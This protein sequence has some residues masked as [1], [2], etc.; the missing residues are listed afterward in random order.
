MKATL[1]CLHGFLGRAADWDSVFPSSLNFRRIN[2]DLFS[3]STAPNET[4]TLNDLGGWVN[5]HSQSQASPRILLGYSLGG[6]IALHSLIQSPE[7]WSA[8]VIVSAHLGLRRD[9]EDER[10]SR[11]MGDQYWAQRFET[12][13]WSEVVEEWDAQ[14][15]FQGGLRSCQR[16]RSRL[17]KDFLRSKLA[18]SFKY[19]SLGNQIDLRPAL[20]KIQVPILWIS[21]E[22]DVK[23][24]SIVQEA[25]E[26]NPRFRSVVI[27]G[28]GHRI[29][30]EMPG[31]FVQLIVNYLKEA[32]L[33]G[34][35]T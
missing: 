14:G 34:R 12:G 21:G 33:H 1:Y 25:A 3:P 13:P 10:G 5:T 27:P 11:L 28:G 17:E 7:H 24:R 6:R 15:V 22:Q 35:S 30:W 16:G 31:E 32:G 2:Y 18:N 4:L 23:Y 20:K 19:C 9:Q 26:L 8:A 29:P